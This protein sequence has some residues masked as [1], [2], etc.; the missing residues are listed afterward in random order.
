MNKTISWIV[1][2]IIIIAVGYFIAINVKSTPADYA[3]ATESTSTTRGEINISFTDATADIKNVSEVT[4]NV[5]KVELYSETK[6]WVSVSNNSAQYQLLDLHAK[7]QTKTYAS[8]SVPTDTY[9]KIRV[10]LGDVVLKMKAGADKTA[11]VPNRTLDIQSIVNVKENATTSVKIDVLADKSLHLTAKGDYVF[12]PVVKIESRSDARIDTSADGIV[13]I[14]EGSL[15]S[16]ST[17]GMDV[18]GSIKAD[19]EIKSDVKLDV[20]SDGVINVIGG[21][22]KTTASSSSGSTVASSTINST[23]SVN[24]NGTVKSLLK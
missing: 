7:G 1:G 8:V 13:T 2:I 16:T 14:S 6:G 18:D 10:A 4:L 17:V 12:A 9:S 23:S 15:D 5:N 11:A 22:L 21:M 20:G 24:V 19:F 3:P